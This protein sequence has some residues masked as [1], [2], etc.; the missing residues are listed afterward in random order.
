MYKNGSLRFSEEQEITKNTNKKQ[1]R[2]SLFSRRQL[3]K[4]PWATDV[5]C[6]LGFSQ[7]RCNIIIY[8]LW[9]TF[10]EELIQIILLLF[11]PR[12]VITYL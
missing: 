12:S 7:V 1:F 3:Q 5:S 10:Q 9:V 2:C 6:F 11:E 8:M 4:F